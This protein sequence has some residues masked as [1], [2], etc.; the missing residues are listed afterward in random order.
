MK[1]ILQ[2]KNLYF[3]CTCTVHKNFN[4]Y[5]TSYQCPANSLAC[6]FY[7]KGSSKLGKALQ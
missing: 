5:F 4:L 6:K 3:V 1:G 7:L 2:V